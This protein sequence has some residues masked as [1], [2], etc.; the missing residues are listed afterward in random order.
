MKTSEIFV[1]ITESLVRE[2]ALA[3]SRGGVKMKK[4]REYLEENGLRLV[5]W[6]NRN[7]RNYMAVEPIKDLIGVE[8]E[9]ESITRDE[10]EKVLKA[11]SVIEI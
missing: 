11:G 2:N 6:T 4:I 7:L 10:F 9:P 5:A 8:Y 1:A 3:A